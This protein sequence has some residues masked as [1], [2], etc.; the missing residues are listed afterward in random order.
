MYGCGPAEH[1]QGE[2]AAEAGGREQAG[3]PPGSQAS[4]RVAVAECWRLGPVGLGP[5]RQPLKAAAAP[6]KI[7]LRRPQASKQAHPLDPFRP[8]VAAWTTCPSP[9]TAQQIRHS[10]H[11]VVEN[12]IPTTSGD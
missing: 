2:G 5:G 10:Q 9:L 1:Q 7:R 6:V 3:Q 12:D 8:T 11:I 4:L